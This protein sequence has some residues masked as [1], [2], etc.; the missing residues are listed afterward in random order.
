MKGLYATI[1]RN[2]A[3]MQSERRTWMLFFEV[4]C[5]KVDNANYSFSGD[6]DLQLK[7]PVEQPI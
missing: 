5:F 6:E 4:T 1:I 3:Q 2:T 7:T